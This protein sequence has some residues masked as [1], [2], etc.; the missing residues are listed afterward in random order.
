MQHRSSTLALFG[1][2]I[3]AGPAPERAH[4]QPATFA[5]LTGAS[6]LPVQRFDIDFPHS[7]VEFS[8]RFMGL[9][10]VRGAFS[11]FGGTFML[12]PAD[13]T[14]S[15]ITVVISTASINTNVASRDKDLKS[16]NFFDAEKY[17]RIIF[18]SSSVERRAGGFLLKGPLTMHGVTREV[19]IPFSELHPLSKDAWGNQRIGYAGSLT[20]SRKEYGILGT[21]FW[22]SEYDPGRMSISDEV[23]VDLT[24]EAELNNVDRW[25]TPKG[26]SLRTAAERQGVPKT[27]QEFRDAARDTG[28][29]AGKFSADM[30][31]AAALKLLHHGKLTEGLE[32]YRLAA[33]LN[34]NRAGVQAALGE[35]YLMTGKRREAVVSFG[36]AMAIDSLNTVAREY[37]RHLGER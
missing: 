37:L 24:L 25:T 8:V 1:C 15:T 23:A 22:N 36:K 3:A 27:L 21:A 28:S 14:R 33:E 18:T 9:S 34:P 32:F 16:P 12:D 29:A 26:D 6:G 4:A 20:L 19:A 35:A 17:P 2:V 10:T 7:S 11:E 5:S 31:G 30:L 13:V